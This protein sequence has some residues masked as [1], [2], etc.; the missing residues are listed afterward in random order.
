M[1]HLPP[2]VDSACPVPKL[3]CYCNPDDYDGQ[4]MPDFSQRAGWRIDRQNGPVRFDE[5]K[6]QIASPIA[7]LQA[8]C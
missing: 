6:S 8:W 5:T 1:A 4:G 3:P 7:L 2:I